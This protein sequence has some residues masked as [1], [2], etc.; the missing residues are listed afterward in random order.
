M[1]AIDTDCLV[2]GAGPAGLSAALWLRRLGLSCLVLERGDQLGGELQRINLPIRDFLG[3]AASD[4]RALL[5]Q[6]E[7]MVNDRDLPVRFSCAV[8]SLALDRCEVTTS[9]GVLRARALILALGLRRRVLD[10]PGEARRLAGGLSYSG[11]T[12]RAAIGTGPVAIVGGGDGAVENALILAD[13]CDQVHLVHRGSHFRAQ[14]QLVERVVAHDRIRLWLESEVVELHGAE[15]KLASVDVATPKGRRNIVVPWLVIK[16]GF[17]PN[18]DVLRA[19]SLILDEAGYVVVDRYLRTSVPAVFAAGDL[20][21]PRAPSIAAA[22][23]DGAVA[24]RGV[25]QVLWQPGGPL[26]GD[27]PTPLG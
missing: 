5:G 7:A 6:I 11:T 2:I 27:A 3:C 10:L 4:G 23:G 13:Q 21:N 25:S 20:C 18:S 16:I 26:A 9:T 24:A 8:E 12:D 14:P 19:T 15:G 1:P 22:V 17:E